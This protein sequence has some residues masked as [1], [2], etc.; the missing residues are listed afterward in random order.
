MVLRKREEP[1]ERQ[2][3]V[4]MFQ[5]LNWQGPL[6]VLSEG[7]PSWSFAL[8]GMNCDN[9][10][11]MCS[12]ITDKVKLECIATTV[13]PTLVEDWDCLTRSLH[14]SGP[15]VVFIQGSLDFVKKQFMRIDEL[16]CIAGVA[17]VPKGDKEMLKKEGWTWSSQIK[18]AEMG[19]LTDG[20][21]DVLSSHSLDLGSTVLRRTLGMILQPVQSGKRMKTRYEIEAA[22]QEGSLTGEE[23]VPR[24]SHQVYVLSPSVFTGKDLVLRKLNPTELMDVYDL[25]VR[26]QSDLMHLADERQWH[27][28]MSFIKVAPGKVVT[29]VGRSLLEQLTLVKG[30]ADEVVNDRSNLDLEKS[31]I[32]ADTSTAGFLLEEFKKRRKDDQAL[33]LQR[34]PDTKAAKEDDAE[35]N[36]ELWDKRSVDNYDGSTSKCGTIVC[37]KDSYAPKTHGRLFAALRLLAHSWSLR[38]LTRSFT[39]YLSKKYDSMG[40][41]KL[42]VMCKGDKKEEEKFYSVA[43]WV[44]RGRKQRS[45]SAKRNKKTSE[46]DSELEKDLTVGV[47]AIRRATEASWWNWDGG[48]TMFFWRWASPFQ[49]KVRDGTPL[50]IYHHK[51]PSNTS[52]QQDHPEPARQEQLKKK[53]N[54]LRTK[55][56]LDPGFVISIL[57]F[58]GVPKGEADVRMVFDATKCELNAALWT[59]NFFLATIESVMM[60][61]DEETWM[62]DL[63]LGEMFLNFWLDEQLRPYAGVD[64]T[65]L[66]RRELNDK[67]ELVYVHQDLIHRIWE[68]WERTC[69]GLKS[70]PYVCTQTFG[71][72]EDAIRG[73]RMDEKNPL[74]WD[75]VILNLP[76]SDG[77]DPSKPW[78]HRICKATGRLASFFG[79]YIDD[80]RSG[81]S[82]ERGC[83][84]VSRRIASLANYLGIQDAPRKRRAPSKTPGAWA[85]SIC[86]PLSGVGLFVAVSQEKWEKGQ[87]MVN[88]WFEQVVVEKRTELSFKEMEKDVGFLIHLSRAYPSLFPYLR[89]F[90]NT[91]NGWRNRRD[92]DG[93][94]LTCKEWEE[95]LLLEE[96]FSLDENGEQLEQDEF[97]SKGKRDNIPAMVKGV[98]RLVNDVTALVKLLKGPVPSLRLVRG[99]G[100]TVVRYGFGDASKAGFGSSWLSSGGIKYRLGIWSA[101]EAENS[102]NWRE[103]QNLVDALKEEAKLGNLKGVEVFLFTDNST[104][105]GAFFNGSS[106]SRKLFELIL[107]LREMEME[108]EMKIH[109]VH[110]SGKRMI[111]QGT[112]GLS[113]GQFTEGVMRGISMKSFIPLNENVCERHAG[114][115]LWVKSWMPEEEAEWLKPEDWFVRGHNIVDGSGVDNGDGLMVPLYKKGLF[116]WTPPP[117]AAGV[118]IE[119]LRK[120]RHKHTDSTHLFVVPRLMAPHWRKHAWKVGDLIVEL[121]AGHEAWPLNMHEPLTLIFV[122]PFIRYEPWEL[123]RTPAFVGMGKRLSKMLKAGDSTTGFVLQQ[124]W[125]RARTL[126]DLSERMVRQLLRSQSGFEVPDSPTRK[127]RRV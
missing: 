97:K 68:R 78:V 122:F 110:V 113:R 108:H 77:Y 89:G 5:V 11:T 125:E 121:P 52:R 17:L 16:S 124:F 27:P 53:V 48:S 114:F 24:G 74:N 36:I 13:G 75:R 35:V 15:P 88:K 1:R 55:R 82:T 83:W 98:A 103:L 126:D 39:R 117:A 80:C 57:N 62:G 118:A 91:M 42:S 65:S 112:D 20:G 9:I 63:D 119:E 111:A 59:P 84:E 107:E 87:M 102:S 30:I 96:D 46:S 106:A 67:G 64:V 79:V 51:L 8:E 45:W 120:A 72:C 37:K 81:A 10:F 61:A 99:K 23:L 7:W 90:Y 12:F 38:R 127:R 60:N 86:V 76:G 95:F 50:F 94:K 19:G 3:E 21:W 25:D 109:F 105:E 18:H 104:A 28:S 116:I 29:A 69:M 26:V 33:K 115:K 41:R 54:G 43:G 56:Y 6:V 47:D 32:N 100:I 31:A 73:N 14:T 66:G 22:V 44:T 40:R 70:S 71:W 58:F 85:G 34:G 93:W 123:K 49:K 4:G 2:E 101:L 92:N